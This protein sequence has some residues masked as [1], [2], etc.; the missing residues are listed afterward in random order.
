MVAMGEF[1]VEKSRWHRVSGYGVHA[2]TQRA[3]IPEEWGDRLVRRHRRD[4]RDAN[5][6]L[7]EREQDAS[8]AAAA[9]VEAEHPR[10]PAGSEQGGEW[11]PKGAMLAVVRQEETDR[12]ASLRRKPGQGTRHTRT[13]E[14]VMGPDGEWLTGTRD[15]LLIQADEFFATLS[16]EEQARIALYAGSDDR[17]LELYAN[18]TRNRLTDLTSIE[19][20][21]KVAVRVPQETIVSILDRGAVLNAHDAAHL[22][23]D[24]S[25]KDAYMTGRTEA[26]RSVWS[27]DTDDPG[28]H[29]IYGYV[30]TDNEV[31][32]E[33]LARAFGDTK[34]TLDDSVRPRTTIT[35][36]DSLFV[37]IGDG[38]V[39]PSP[40]D[41][42]SEMS[43][44]SWMNLGGVEVPV[45]YKGQ[46]PRPLPTLSAETEKKITE[47]VSWFPED[48]R[49]DAIMSRR[50]DEAEKL[51]YR[52]FRSGDFIEAQIHGGVTIRDITRV[53]FSSGPGQDILDRLDEAGIPWTIGGPE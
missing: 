39:V 5:A 49:A 52:R 29:P 47:A 36:S 14:P 3:Q 10:H 32:G 9:Y 18:Y 30:A 13:T 51:G 26:E 53:D 46:E 34:L 8:L 43:V 27:I 16:D 33:S 15:A 23:N 7:D 22:S 6:M 40:I 25:S 17:K 42:P 48:E 4:I 2:D 28:A 1:N 12:A 41:S 31:V 24:R 44:V 37:G 38:D 20:G 35:Y 50:I 19:S 11:A 21:A 45:A